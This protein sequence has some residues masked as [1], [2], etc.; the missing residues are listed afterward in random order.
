M[1]V[2]WSGAGPS[3]KRWESW[4]SVALQDGPEAAAPPPER[5]LTVT[6]L[7]AL[8]D[9]NPK[10]VSL[11]DAAGRLPVHLVESGAAPGKTETLS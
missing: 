6:I 3:S 1:Q 7:G 11:A 5:L 2:S 4:A 9:A 10:C 8:I